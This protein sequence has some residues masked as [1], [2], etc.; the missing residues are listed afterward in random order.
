[1]RSLEIW[2]L[3]RHITTELHPRA[4]TSS[5]IRHKGASRLIHEA[6]SRTL[7]PK[8]VVGIPVLSPASSSLRLRAVNQAQ[9]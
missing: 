1:M 8:M 3:W 2:Q 5:A 9:G 4:M 6:V 7:V